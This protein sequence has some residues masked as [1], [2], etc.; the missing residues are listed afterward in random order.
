MPPKKLKVTRSIASKKQRQVID[1]LASVTSPP[2]SSKTKKS[3]KKQASL[4]LL[5][6][7]KG[8]IV[9]AVTETKQARSK[10]EN[11]VATTTIILLEAKARYLYLKSRWLLSIQNLSTCLI[12]IT[13]L[14]VINMK[15]GRP[16]LKIISS[17]TMS[18]LTR[19][20]VEN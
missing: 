20:L 13:A 14:K 17:P 8:I 9:Q 15:F 1:S 6:R 7:E 3:P 4:E 19:F 18:S 10:D 5:E 16:L 12:L 2:K 11:Q